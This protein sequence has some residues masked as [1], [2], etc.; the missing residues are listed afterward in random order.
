MD[1]AARL[2]LAAP[3]AWQASSR[4]EMAPKAAF[5]TLKLESLNC[6]VW[7]A[8]TRMTG[9]RKPAGSRRKGGANV[10]GFRSKEHR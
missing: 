5:S 1:I 7:A 10:F 4:V 8:K 3:A 2:P 6:L 9:L